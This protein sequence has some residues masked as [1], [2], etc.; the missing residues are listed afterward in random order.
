MIKII[1]FIAYL[2]NNVL[3]YEVI[4][5]RIVDNLGRERIF[6]GVN[7]IYKSKPWYPVIDRFDYTYSFNEDDIN[8]IKNLGLNVIRLGVMWPGVEPN[9]GFYNMTYLNLMKNII[10][11]LE[12]N[13][14]YVLVDFHQDS[15]SEYFCGEGIPDWVIKNSN[16]PIPLG[17]PYNKHGKPSRKDCLSKKWWEYQFSYEAGMMYQKLYTDDTLIDSFLGYWSIVAETFKN[18][19]N[20]IGYEII[21]EPW[22]G[23]IYEDPLLLLQKHADKKYLQP[24]YDKVYNN[25]SKYLDDKLL[26]FESVTWDIDGV[27]FEHPPGFNNTKCILSYHCY[28]PP[29]LSVEKMFRTRMRDINRLNVGGFMTELGSTNILNIFEL[30]DKNFQSWSVWQYKLFAGITGDG[31]MFFNKDGTNAST[32]ENLNRIY[33]IAICGH[34]LYFNYNNSEETAKLIY[35]NNPKCFGLTEIFVKNSRNITIS[36]RLKIYIINNIVYIPPHKDYVNITVLIC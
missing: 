12:K 11:K 32:R 5:N 10:K 13:G 21:N 16:F 23:N 7:V 29:N 35:T 20:V 24:F 8:I 4:N 28:F 30:S 36:Y 3:A 1:Y 19:D 6:H 15:L 34:G 33:P 18:S 2:L 25:I 26:F 14:I 22:A 27:G 9:K 31:S 17:L